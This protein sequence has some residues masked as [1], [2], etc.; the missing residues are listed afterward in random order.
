MLTLFYRFWVKLNVLVIKI[1][2]FF[3]SEKSKKY[4]G[5][6]MMWDFEIFLVYKN[7]FLQEKNY[8]RLF[9][10]NLKSSWWVRK[11][12]FDFLNDFYYNWESWEK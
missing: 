10:L 1:T 8:K 5:Y 9:L 6:T 11:S 3:D 7:F 12:L 4:I 2:Y